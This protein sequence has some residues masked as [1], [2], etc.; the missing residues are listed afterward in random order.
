MKQAIFFLTRVSPKRKQKRSDKMLGGIK[1]AFTLHLHWWHRQE[2][3][4]TY[5]DKSPI[6]NGTLSDE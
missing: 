3:I 1:G 5:E 6:Y 2:Y 4:F